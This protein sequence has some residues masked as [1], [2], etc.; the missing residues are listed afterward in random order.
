MVP[1]SY[2]LS[3]FNYTLFIR[4]V[5]DKKRATEKNDIVNNIGPF[6]TKRI[7]I[8]LDVIQSI[9][10]ISSSLAKNSISYDKNVKIK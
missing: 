8:Q 7:T 6:I 4:L 1:D 3:F 9:E 10:I 5:S 2:S